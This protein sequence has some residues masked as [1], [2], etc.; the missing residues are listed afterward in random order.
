MASE[1]GGAE[2]TSSSQGGG[3]GSG[4]DAGSGNIPS[5]RFRGVEIIDAHG[6]PLGEFDE[7]AE[8]PFIEE[9]SATGFGQLHPRTGQ[10]VQTVAQ[11]AEKQIFQKTVVRLH[12]LQ[13]AAT[14]RPAAGGSAR[15]PALSEILRIRKFQFKIM[16]T[17]PE[18]QNA[19][20]AQLTRLRA[21][22]PE[23]E[24]SVIFGP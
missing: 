7:I 15:I 16:S 22:F 24:F 23:W 18:I 2:T 9:K 5:Q 13:R 3:G 4:T 17:A 6:K 21:R 20:Q 14:T 12:N 1:G 11:W 8:G 10:P 19:V